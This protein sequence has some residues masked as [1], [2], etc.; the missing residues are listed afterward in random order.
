MS[1]NRV[2]GSILIPS[3]RSA[4]TLDHAGS[5]KS[6]TETT[7]VTGVVKEF[8]SDPLT[9]S[10]YD[11]NKLKQVVR[12]SNLVE[13]MPINSIHCVVIENGR[14]DE[15]VAYPFFSQH[16][17]VPVKPGEQVWLVREGNL[18]YWFCRK[19]GDY[20]SEDLNYTH[21]DR[22]VN[23]E[24]TRVSASQAFSRDSQTPEFPNGITSSETDSTL[25]VN[26]DYQKIVRESQSYNT[27]FVP[28]AVPRLTK[29]PGDLLLQG[30]NNTAILLG[31]RGGQGE[32]KIVTGRKITS[33]TVSNSRN[34]QEIDKSNSASSDSKND[35]NENLS[36]LNV[37]M[38]GNIDIDFGVNINGIDPS[39]QGAG[40]TIKSDQIRLIARQDI[41][42]T[43]DNS[44]AGI[45]I[46]SNGEIVIVPA[47]TSVIKL[48]GDDANKAILCQDI[49]PG[50]D[51]VGNVQA[52]PVVSTMGGVIGS[53][54]IPGTGIFASKVLVK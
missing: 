3:V 22:G 4:S 30:S 40:V 19:T 16:L 24:A 43:V 26:L 20:S 46:K 2:G 51:A 50:T 14:R 47:A 31:D 25:G 29:K 42:I 9:L 11:K 45:V 15:H 10:E 8:F 21:I 49:I 28:T 54:T 13:R 32:I 17:C 35:D 6:N 37:S 52:P 5:G 18:H 33:N 48:G 23:Q 39:G 27:Q 41:K 38:D 44:G 1:L 34:Y 7:F 36:S 12:S 53:S